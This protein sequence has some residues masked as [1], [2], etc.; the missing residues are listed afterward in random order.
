MALAGFDGETLRLSNIQTARPRLPAALP[1]P[2]LFA[3]LD[4]G[5][6]VVWVSGPPGAGKTTLVASYLG[7][8]R[9][10][11]LWYQLDRGDTDIAAFFHHLAAAAGARRGRTPLPSMRPEDWLG[12]PL[13]ARRWFEALYARLRPP[14][15]LVLDDAH[16]VPGESLFHDAIREG[17]AALPDGARAIVISRSGPPPALTR[18]RASRAMTMIG[19]D[20]LRLTLAETRGVA[21]LLGH[22]RLSREAAGQ[23]HVRTAGWA[24]GLILMLEGPSG[25]TRSARSGGEIAGEALFDYFAGEI[26]DATGPAARQVLLE[27][28]H[29]PA[30]TAQMAVELTG[31]AGAGEILAGL[32]RRH[33]FTERRG[34]PENTYQYHPLF[35]D[36][37]LAR[38]R[39]VLPATRLAEVRRRAAA[40]LA[41]AGQVEAAAGLLRESGDAGAL[42]GLIVSQ[43][44]ALV[45]QG[46]MITLEEWTGWLPAGEAGRNGWLQYW[47][48]VARV[49]FDPARGRRHLETAFRIFVA[50]RVPAGLFAAWCWVVGSLLYEWSAFARL[51]PW[52]DMLEGLRREHPAPLSPELEASVAANTFYALMFRR[53]EDP[54]VRRCAERA[55]ALS[56]TSRDPDRRMLT[57]FL[58]ATYYL[59]MGDIARAG[60]ALGS[61]EELARAPGVSPLV[62]LTCKGVEAYHR[63]HVGAGEQALASASEGLEIARVTGVH[64]MDGLLLAQAVYAALTTG[65]LPAA[66]GYLRT[67]SAAVGGSGSL[68]EGHHHFLAGWE[69]LLGRDVPRALEHV[70]A[71]LGLDSGAPYPQALNHLAMA[72]VLHARGEHAE[73]AAHLDRARAAGRRMG[74]HML[75]YACLLADA[76]MAVDRG[77]DEAG[78]RALG[79]AMSLGRRQGLVHAPW[80]RPSV[81]ARLC[82]RALE[83]GIEA[84]HVKDLIRRCDLFPERPPLEMEQWPWA[85]RVHTLGGFRLV[86]DGAPLE[87]AGKVQ[88]R[89]LGLLKAVAALGARGVAE[90]ALA[91]A[92]WP[93][94][95]G[96]AARAALA[97][98]LHRLRRLL[99]DERAIRIAEGRA[100]LDSRRLWLDSAAFEDLLDEAGSAERQAQRDRAAALTERALAL[101]RGPFLH[102]ERHAP[103]AV[104]A[105]ERLRSK[106]LRHTERLARH[107]ADAGRWAEAAD[108]YE[109]GLEADDLAEELYRGLMQCHRA[110]GRR[111]EALAVHERCR[112]ALAAGLGVAPSPATE[113]LRRALRSG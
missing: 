18:L 45:A 95:E 63:W 40:L 100:S 52:I 64:L 86:R 22:P 39:D 67:M 48:G 109:R 61:L 62:R 15:V 77:E 105:R 49:P 102:G 6:R 1:R 11:S 110:L 10:R 43:A 7:S 37:L 47:L 75:D 58:A 94:A 103:W 29:L 20:T 56:A 89:P 107:R 13:F 79:A 27:T 101:Y 30:M 21:R 87:F 34:H 65:D 113:A 46:R 76:E 88:Q 2:R 51:D 97:T 112:R 99:G 24:A 104:A 50:E 31:F 71:A 70:R 98:T 38:A 90:E 82:A 55:V 81:M 16:E 83:A 8:R 69:A 91:D 96:D 44:P 33:Y 72:L 85:L 106:F 35:R 74:S 4:R 5:R 25:A 32:A 14:F 84:E 73:A 93:E 68:H 23:L 36:F 80:W 26:L 92:L 12:L 19:A 53:P 66:R 17:V 59:W 108:C 41:G 111:A 3:L 28:A 9:M 57:A 78:L 54:A 42:A 60:I